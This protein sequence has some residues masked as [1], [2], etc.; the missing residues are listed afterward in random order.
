MNAKKDPR[1]WD[2]GF[3]KMSVFRSPLNKALIATLLD[4]FITQ[5]DHGTIWK[6]TNVHIET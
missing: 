3:I 5:L 6:D 2:P 1:G 4:F